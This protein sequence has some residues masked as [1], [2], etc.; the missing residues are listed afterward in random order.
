MKLEIG[1]RYRDVAGRNVTITDEEP[2]SDYTSGYRRPGI[3]IVRGSN[4]GDRPNTELDYF[5]DGI[6]PYMEDE[7]YNI[8]E[9]ILDPMPVTVKKEDRIELSTL[10]PDPGCPRAEV[11]PKTLMGRLKTPVLSV[12]PPASL[13]HQ[14]DAMNYGA[15]LAPKADGTKG[16]GPYNWRDAPIEAG[17]YVDAAMRHLMQWW[18]GEDLASD[19]KAHHL[20]HA[21]ATIGILLDAIENQTVIDD[22]P[23]V[24]KQV[25]TK[26][27]AALKARGTGT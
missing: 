13:I 25:A 26:L 2:H 8:V 11:N 23:T 16:Y 7:H 14:A 20:G 27:F 22:R 10:V 3:G 6:C 15:Y 17:V 24:N 5:V 19:S 1:K 18:D 4:N 9:E 12:I 21:L